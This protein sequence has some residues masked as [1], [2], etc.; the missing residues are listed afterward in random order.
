MLEY[1]LVFAF[2]A[3]PML[4]LVEYLL[5]VLSDYFGLIAYYVTLPFL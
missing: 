5:E 1:A 4:L 2:V 3:L